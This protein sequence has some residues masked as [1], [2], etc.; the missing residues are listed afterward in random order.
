MNKREREILGK[1]EVFISEISSFQ[2]HP[3]E[4]ETKKRKKEKKP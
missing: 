3:L 2:T 4:E 1:R